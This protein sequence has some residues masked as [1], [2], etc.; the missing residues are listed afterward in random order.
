MGRA[1]LDGSPARGEAHPRLLLASYHCYVDPS[2]G[3]AIATRDLLHLLVKRGWDVRVFCGPALD[4]EQGESLP[5]LLSDQGIPFHEVRRSAT[6]LPYS[7]LQFQDHALRAAVYVPS[8]R[9]GRVP[10]R[11]EGAVF[12]DLLNG[13]LDDFR[14][15]LLLTYG[16]HWVA[17]ETILAARRRG[18]AVV[19]A[20]HN[21]AYRDARLFEAVSAVLVPSKFC[22]SYYRRALG[23]M[24]TA[25]PSPL[26][27]SRI[28]CQRPSGGEYVTFVNP[29]PYKGVY[30]FA[31][32]VRELASQRPDIPVLVVEGRGTADWLRRTGVDFSGVETLNVMANTPDPRDFYSQSRVLLMPSL[33]NESFGRVAAEAL[34]NGIPVLASRRGALPEVLRDAGFLFDI[35]EHHTPQARIVPSAEEVAPWIK[36]IVRLWDDAAY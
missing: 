30:F 10:S 25:I 21:S 13:A 31:R 12:L 23:I 14:P 16:G 17:G 22:A 15:H 4:F 20:L 9:Q 6:R 5:Q 32:I 18:I 11:E 29:Q 28:R 34:I 35:P 24:S 19:F 7:V 36:T 26:D 33:C 1:L 2:S 3:A 8:V 27:W